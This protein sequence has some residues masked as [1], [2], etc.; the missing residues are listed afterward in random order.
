MNHN[1]SSSSSLS[2]KE[3]DAMSNPPEDSNAPQR[4]DDNNPTSHA[5]NENDHSDV[6]IEKAAPAKPQ[7]PPPGA[8]NPLENPDGGLKAWLCVLGSFC[9]LFC[10]FGWINWSVANSHVTVHTKD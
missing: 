7:G 5:S 6:D 3:K 8:F 1:I 2:E 10:S 9:A 4:A